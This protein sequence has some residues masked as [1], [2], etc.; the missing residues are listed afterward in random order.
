MINMAQK[1]DKRNQHY[2]PKCYLRN[3]TNGDE[4]IAT[5]LHS[6]NKFVE[7]ASLDSV[8]CKEYLYGKDL[9]IEKKFENLEGKWASAFKSINKNEDV[10]DDE[11]IEI[12]YQLMTFI[13]FQHSRT[14]R[15]F[16]AQKSFEDFL[17]N[18]V[19]ENA[20][21]E[22]AARNTLR[23][24]IPKNYNLME[25]PFNVSAQFIEAFKD[26]DL[27]LIENNSEID[28]VTS[29]N[30]VVLYNKFLCNRKFQGNYGLSA[31]GLCIFL[32]LSPN[33][34]LCLFDP[35]IYF[36]TNNNIKCTIS[37]DSAHELN[38]MFCRNAYEYVF[39]SKK[40]SK[41]YAEKLDGFFVDKLESKTSLVNSNLGEVIHFMNPSILEVYELP[42]ITQRR[43][44]K[45]ISV[46][47]L[48]PAP[49]RYLRN[50]IN[51]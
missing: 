27:L 37:Q 49:Q 28:F 41:E 9:V 20:G 14:L 24:Y 43:N 2:V 8:V 47:E 25:A 4:F 26:L 45:R 36:S 40:H 12:V 11:A 13:A 51:R 30:P 34:C 18:F 3:F 23:K 42:F 39:F 10:T 6:K 46:P 17:Y 35:K 16:D 50:P 1:N 15:V 29:D 22:E 44:S 21:S 19:C 5:F 48:G 31:V 7:K 32:P 38:K 33:L